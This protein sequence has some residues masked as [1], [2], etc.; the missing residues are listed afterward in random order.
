MFKLFFPEFTKNYNYWI[1]LG[2]S[3]L[4]NE[5]EYFFNEI[6]DSPAHFLRF[7]KNTIKIVGFFNKI[8]NICNN[9][10]VYPKIDINNN[11]IRFYIFNNINLFYK[12]NISTHYNISICNRQPN[13]KFL[14][15][16]KDI[17][18][19]FIH[20]NAKII[21]EKNYQLIEF[22][23]YN[24]KNAINFL[25]IIM[26]GTILQI[27]DLYPFSRSLAKT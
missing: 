5:K 6:G 23:F 11:A 14:L 8:S 9:K 7:S 22:K 12:I 26:N 24:E 25:R 4:V 27:Q 19:V 18:N 3:E 21:D 15:L 20:L 1:E 10:N 17:N 16:L 2:G 13:N